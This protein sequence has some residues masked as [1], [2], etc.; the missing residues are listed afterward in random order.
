MVI[1]KVRKT[2]ALANCESATEQERE[3]AL[4]MAH[5]L[6]AKHNL[7]MADIAEVGEKRGDY[8]VHAVWMP[9]QRM[10]ANAV[11]KLC[12]CKFVGERA[13][14]LRATQH[15][16]GTEGNSITAAEMAVYVMGSIDR[17]SRV[18]GGGTSFCVGA[19]TRIAH[20]INDMIREAQQVEA[21]PGTSVVLADVYRTEEDQNEDVMRQLFGRLTTSKVKASDARAYAQGSEYGKTVGLHRQATGATQKRLK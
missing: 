2:L 1:E 19:A 9:W 14:G 17:E 8:K 7:S 20:R 3:T 21:T 12:F 11:A 10:V 13:K 5:A 6:L 16:I 18:V 4:R 15:F